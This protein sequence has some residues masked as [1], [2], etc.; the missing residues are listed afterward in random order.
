MMLF[1]HTPFCNVLLY[2]VHF[3]ELGSN[4]VAIVWGMLCGAEE[5]CLVTVKLAVARWAAC[6]R[7]P[8]CTA[9]TRHRLP[10]TNPHN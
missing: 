3:G 5:W 7:L 2:A 10:D 4:D 1:V 9:R 8:T 6:P